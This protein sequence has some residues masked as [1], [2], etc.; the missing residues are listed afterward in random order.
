MSSQAS[1]RGS[2][3]RLA[4]AAGAR[5]LLLSVDRS[6]GESLATE[7]RC[8][9]WRFAKCQSFW[10]RSR[11]VRAT[12][13][14]GVRCVRKVPAC[15]CRARLGL[16]DSCLGSAAHSRGRSPAGA[17]VSTGQRTPV[18]E[19][20]SPRSIGRN[21]ECSGG[22]NRPLVITCFRDTFLKW[23]RVDADEHRREGGPAEA[24]AA[25]LPPW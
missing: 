19:R 16:G 21:R 1:R 18:S 5:V 15:G 13:T 6:L 14:E 4:A 8:D 9:G 3:R 11:P 20:R 2:G 23:T 22:P 12:R 17:A 7:Q 25:A 24:A 10:K